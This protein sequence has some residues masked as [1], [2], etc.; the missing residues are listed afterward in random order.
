MVPPDRDLENLLG[1]FL[2]SHYA[3]RRPLV[4]VR[5]VS[6][7]KPRANFKFDSTDMFV[8]LLLFM[9]P[10]RGTPVTVQAAK[11]AAVCTCFCFGGTS[12]CR[13]RV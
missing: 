10:S 11:M 4:G 9:E 7:A 1:P 3:D 12:L 13:F 6:K 2:P 5:M 8:N